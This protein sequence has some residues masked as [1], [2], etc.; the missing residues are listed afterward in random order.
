LS[1]PYMKKVKKGPGAPPPQERKAAKAA[2]RKEE[3][4]NVAPVLITLPWRNIRAGYARVRDIGDFIR[5]Y[6]MYAPLLAEA[7]EMLI[8]ARDTGHYRYFDL[9]ATAG[10][11]VVTAIDKEGYPKVL[12]EIRKDYWEGEPPPGPP[13]ITPL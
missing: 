11:I 5:F 4:A 7:K 2:A 12:F 13:P 3:L 8:K 1:D 6:E 10:G 9:Y